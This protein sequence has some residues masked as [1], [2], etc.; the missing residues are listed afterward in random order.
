MVLNNRAN[1]V[2]PVDLGEYLSYFSAWGG[3]H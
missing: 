2:V 3:L 1:P